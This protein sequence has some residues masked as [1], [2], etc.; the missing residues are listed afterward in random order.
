M[1]DLKQWEMHGPVRTLRKELAE[2]NPDL[3]GWQ[4][5]RGLTILAFRPDGQ[6]SESEYHNP[7]GSVVRRARVYGDSGRVTEDQWWTNDVL[8]NRVLHMYDVDGRPASSVAVDADG[9]EREAEL[10]R[11]DDLGRKTKVVFLR[12]PEHS[13]ANFSHGVE[14]TDAAYPAPGATTSTTTYDERELPSE[15]SFHDATMLWSAASY[16]PEIEKDVC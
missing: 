1:S 8:T 5:P 11:Y 6:L 3:G 7:D 13:A 16:F 10:C 15:V 12:V 4:P 2:W 9:T 14:G